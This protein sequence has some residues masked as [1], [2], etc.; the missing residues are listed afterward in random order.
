[1]RAELPPLR[2][3]LLRWLLI[4][5]L[6]LLAID[7]LISVGVATGFAEQGHD[8]AL[9]EIAREIGLG[10]HREAQSGRARFGLSDSTLRILLDDDEDR[11]DFVVIG[12]MGGPLAGSVALHRVAIAFSDARGRRLH[13]AELDGVPV[14][15][16]QHVP[17]NVDDVVVWVAESRNKRNRLRREILFAVLAPQVILIAV[18]AGLV[19]VGVTR[20]LRPLER[21][22]RSISMRSQR[23][24]SPMDASAVPGEL[25]PLVQSFNAM[26]DRLGQVLE[27][28]SRFIADAAHQL[29]TPV[30]VLRANVE[31][32]ERDPGG[33]ERDRTI[34]QIALGVE[35][36]SRLVSQLLALARNEPGAAATMPRIDIDLNALLLDCASS[37]VPLALR[38]NIDLGFEAPSVPVIVRGDPIRLRELFDNLIDNAIRYSEE[39]G[40][41]TVRLSADDGPSVMICDDGPRIPDHERMR[42]FERFHRLLGREEGTGL[43]L[44]I[45]Q[46]IAQLHHAKI[47]LQGDETDGV[48][49]MFSV[50]F[51][52][53]REQSERFL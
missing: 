19:W 5:L 38:R 13:D 44:A 2:R 11:I 50:V 7:T 15:V 51:E 52:N 37:W 35:R 48:G 9:L 8:K 46:E 31:L 43:G 14:R 47:L 39:G 17:P 24:L 3:Q 34:T 32:L 45:A 30:A 6:G 33:A 27:V 40:R 26:F 12:A 36:M 29:K 20:G 25:R 28:Q 49:N 18:A 41:V 16:A 42:V 21:M 53:Q 22:R 1:M 23:D 10:V 4:P